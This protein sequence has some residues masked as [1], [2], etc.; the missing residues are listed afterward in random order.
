MYQPCRH[1]SEDETG[2]QQVHEG[3][4]VTIFHPTISTDESEYTTFVEKP[5]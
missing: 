5:Q 4:S 1:T 3:A 2:S